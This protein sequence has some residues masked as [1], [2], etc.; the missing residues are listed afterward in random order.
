MSHLDLH[1]YVGVLSAAALHGAGHQ[2]PMVFQVIANRATR[3]MQAGR[4]RIKV[5]TSRTVKAMPVTRVETE[6]G[7][8]MVGTP[9][10]TAF[11]VV[12]FFSAAGHWSNV[13]T[14]LSELA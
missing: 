13:A 11:D 1:Y 14:V 3:P 5:H 9:E 7:F 12:R 6:T 8:M 10:T 4:V 2:Q